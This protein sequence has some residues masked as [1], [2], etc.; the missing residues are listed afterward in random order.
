MRTPAVA[1][2]GKI[3]RFS[4]PYISAASAW[5]PWLIS[6]RLAL[7]SCIVIPTSGAFRRSCS[8]KPATR[9]SKNSSRL[10]LTMHRKRKRSSS[11]VIGSSARARTR[12]LKARADSSRL[13]GDGSASF[14]VPGLCA[15]NVT[16]GR[17]AGGEAATVSEL[18]MTGSLRER[19]QFGYRH[20]PQRPLERKPDA[21][22][23]GF[24]IDVV[25]IGPMRRELSGRRLEHA[26]RRQVRGAELRGGCAGDGD[27]DGQGLLAARHGQIHL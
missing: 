19:G 2:A 5:A 11:G 10:L 17:A 9:I 6:P 3:C 23:A 8:R 12:R 24:A 16:V 22:P 15:V 13:I 27:I 20:R 25:K 14:A 1:S 26:Q 7:S 18:G 21:A 4:T